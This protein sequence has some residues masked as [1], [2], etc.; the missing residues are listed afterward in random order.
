[1][2]LRSARPSDAVLNV[3]KKIDDQ[4]GRIARAEQEV[5]ILRRE[6][7]E[8]QETECPH[9]FVSAE[10]CDDCDKYLGPR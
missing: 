1:M 8:M 4:Y 9:T 10:W 3:R 5:E 2:T 7:R 6:L